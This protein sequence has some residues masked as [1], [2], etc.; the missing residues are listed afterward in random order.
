[1]KKTQEYITYLTPEFIYVPFD[2]ERLLNITKSRKVY[3]NGYLGV[4]S[5]NKIYFNYL[6][7]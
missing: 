7:F 2:D 6:K 1:M 5:K 4:N 3:H